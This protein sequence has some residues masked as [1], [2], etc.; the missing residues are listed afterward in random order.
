MVTQPDWNEKRGWFG[1]L[2]AD[3]ARKVGWFQIVEDL[4]N[5]VMKFGLHLGKLS[6]F[7]PALEKRRW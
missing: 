5:Q 1:S 2:M 3:V 6:K 4:Y 7:E